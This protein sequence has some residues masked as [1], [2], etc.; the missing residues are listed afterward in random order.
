[1]KSKKPRKTRWDWGI[2]RKE[3]EKI[4]NGEQKRLTQD[5]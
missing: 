5:L 4:K 2:S 3:R 1:M